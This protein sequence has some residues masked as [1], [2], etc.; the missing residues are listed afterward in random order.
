MEALAVERRIWIDASRDRIWQA[1]TEPDQIVKWLVP[2]LPDA[3]MQR[4][5]DGKLTMHLGPVSIDIAALEGIQPQ[6]QVTSR[7]L[8][9]KLITTTYML[10][11]DNG[12]TN[13][14]V[15]MHGFEA[16]LPNTQQER[17]DLSNQAWEKALSNL[18]AYINGETLPFPHAFVSPL[19]GYWREAR[20]TLAAERSIWINTS[21][22]RVWQAITDPKIFQL[23]YSPTTPWE[24]TALEVGGRLFV[25]NEETGGEMY[26]EV[27]EGID[28]LHKLV[29]R[30]VPE[31]PDTVVKGRTYTLADENGG[32]RLTV[33]LSGYEQE[34]E[35]TRWGNLEQNTFGFGL[36]LQ[37]VKAYLEGEELPVPWGF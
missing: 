32:T 34:P 11:E 9:D 18:K 30:I 29:T 4:A 26:V 33:T 3:Q 20:N 36:V 10:D 13:V 7:S 22:E 16:L 1:I 6:R 31:P 23:W 25:R 15:S 24:L 17:L 35:D 19:F 5:E 8:P 37:N 12:G 14:T 27:I 21:R 28:P 2:N